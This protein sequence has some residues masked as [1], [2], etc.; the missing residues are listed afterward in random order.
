MV[1]ARGT[2]EESMHKCQVGR[3]AERRGARRTAV[4]A[5]LLAGAVAVPIASIAA[6]PVAVADGEAAGTRIEITD[7]QRSSGDTVTLKFTLINDTEESINPYGIFNGSDLRGVYLVDAVGK[8][9]YPTIMDAKN[10]CVCSGNL[11]GGLD[12]GKTMNL[13]AK[14]PA[15]PPGVNEVGVIFPS[16]QP[17]DAP[18]GE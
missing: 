11:P 16:F 18:L 1:K 15:P 7:F 5:S 10:Q 3:R 8:K 14:F 13:W 9:K 2:M 17:V 6:Q 4:F 12:P